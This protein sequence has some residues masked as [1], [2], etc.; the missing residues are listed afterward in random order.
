MRVGEV[1]GH[2]QRVVEVGQR[3]AGVRGAGVE[4][5]LRARLDA[6]AGRFVGVGPGEVV[7]HD[8]CGVAE[9]AL[10]PPA[11]G[12]DPGH[13]HGAGEDAEV[14]GRGIFGKHV[15]V[16]AN[17]VGLDKRHG[18]K[19]SVFAGMPRHNQVSLGRVNTY[20]QQR[21]R[22]RQ[23]DSLRSPAGR[24]KSLD[25]PQTFPCH[26]QA[27]QDAGLR[28]AKIKHPS[29]FVVEKFVRSKEWF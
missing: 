23:L 14:V 4:H 16:A 1:F 20:A 22:F 13:V 9:S 10:E 25:F 3:G 28:F 6:G 8:A 24:P 19:A 29:L 5:G 15:V 27:A 7:V 2:R 11:Y 26:W 18:D 17:H 21:G 12:A